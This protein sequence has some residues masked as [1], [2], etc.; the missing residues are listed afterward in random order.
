[1]DE[2][3]Q[4]RDPIPPSGDG[5]DGGLLEDP[6][7]SDELDFDSGAGPAAAEESARDYTTE[8]LVAGWERFFSDYEYS[9]Q[10]EQVADQFPLLLQ[11]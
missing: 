9:P 4:D 8:Q 7:L 6:L 1:M 3:E 10:I 2:Q 5:Y 11:L